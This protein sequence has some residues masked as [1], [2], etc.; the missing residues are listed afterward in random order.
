MPPHDPP[1]SSQQASPVIMENDDHVEVS[2]FSTSEEQ[3]LLD[4][5]KQC[6]I[7]TVAA[8]SF[9]VCILSFLL[10]I[11]RNLNLRLKHK[12]S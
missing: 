1:M 8:L 3:L 2:S 11:C 4:F 10:Y 7:N 9:A 5:P 12:W 6:L